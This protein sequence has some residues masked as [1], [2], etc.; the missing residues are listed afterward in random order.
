MLTFFVDMKKDYLLKQT[1]QSYLPFETALT[2]T[3]IKVIWVLNA[4]SALIYSIVT[5][6]FYSSLIGP[7]SG[8]Q[9]LFWFLLFILPISWTINFTTLLA[10]LVL[11]FK[12]GIKAL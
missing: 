6:I 4:F 12:Q 7:E 1:G 5:S 11:F 3:L 10:L 8:D 9:T 2:I